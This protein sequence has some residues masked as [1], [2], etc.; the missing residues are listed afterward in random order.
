MT[1]KQLDKHNESDQCEAR[2]NIH[3]VYILNLPK[4]YNVIETGV[5]T[6]QCQTQNVEFLQRLYNQAKV[7][8]NNYI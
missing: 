3:C 1:I 7:D 2:E 5:A 4:L 8:K 6:L